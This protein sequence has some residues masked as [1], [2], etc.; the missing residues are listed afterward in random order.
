MYH[1]GRVRM[2]GGSGRAEHGNSKQPVKS[3]LV[4]SRPDDRYPIVDQCAVPRHA[5]RYG[6]I[7]AVYS[8]EEQPIG[9]NT[10]R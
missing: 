1:K 10:S 2:K 5:A 3:Y 6:R 8:E 4:L 9:P 7:R